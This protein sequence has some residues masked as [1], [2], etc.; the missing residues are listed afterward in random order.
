MPFQGR[1]VAGTAVSFEPVQE[2][3]NEYRL[4]TGA[5]IKM[6]VV[7]G[8]MIIADE[9]TES[10]QPLVIVHSNILIQYIETAEGGVK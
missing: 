4:E 8:T 9:K 3:W 5:R 10:G 6:R 7:P 1:Q 2:H